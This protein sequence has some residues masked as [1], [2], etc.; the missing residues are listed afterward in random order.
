MTALYEIRFQSDVDSEDE[1]TV[2]RLRWRDSAA[3]EV[4]GNQA[5]VA[6]DDVAA[7]VAEFAEMMR[8]SYWAQCGTLEA[9]SGLLAAAE[10]V[11]FDGIVLPVL[12]DQ[13]IPLFEIYC[14]T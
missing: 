7:E 14:S 11:E 8:R 10:E 6:V 4:L 1:L 12:L 13:A 3:G 5:A 9:V 2:L